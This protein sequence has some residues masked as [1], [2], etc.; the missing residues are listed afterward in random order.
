M[1]NVLLVIFMSISVNVK[2]PIAAIISDMLFT[3]WLIDSLC[4][5]NTNQ[6]LIVRGE[7]FLA[8]FTKIIS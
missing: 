5:E 6:G 2:Q 7:F 4:E 3:F 8:N 1:G